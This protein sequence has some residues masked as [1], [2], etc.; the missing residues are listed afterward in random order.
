MDPKL[1]TPPCSSAAPCRATSRMADQSQAVFSLRKTTKQQPARA[2]LNSALNRHQPSFET[3]YSTHRYLL[4]YAATYY[5]SRAQASSFST[6]HSN[7]A[8]P[9]PS[10]PCV[11]ATDARYASCGSTRKSKV[12]RASSFCALW[13]GPAAHAGEAT[14]VAP[15]DA[16]SA[17]ASPI[18]PEPPNERSKTKVGI[19]STALPMRGCPSGPSYGYGYSWCGLYS[20]G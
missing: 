14:C 9:P 4:G 6:F 11:S 20:N 2:Q 8:S 18:P 10:G 7:T 1:P 13:L 3:G 12:G 5:T 17:C 16:R 15:A 19:F